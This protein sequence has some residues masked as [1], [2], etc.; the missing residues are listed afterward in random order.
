MCLKSLDLLEN[1]AWHTLQVV[2]D[3]SLSKNT[4]AG[5]V[6]FFFLASLCLAPLPGKAIWAS[7]AELS[8]TL[9]PVAAFARRLRFFLSLPGSIL[10]SSSSGLT[11]SAHH[12]YLGFLDILGEKQ[13]LSLMSTTSTWGM[14]KLRLTYNFLQDQLPKFVWRRR[15]LVSFERCIDAESAPLTYQECSYNVILTKLIYIFTL[16]SLFMHW[17]SFHRRLQSTLL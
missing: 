15:N 14:F 10:L 3:V 6:S 4:G 11:A 1:S 17:T 12:L 9:W 8:C 7:L 16:L 2:C 13:E 5:P